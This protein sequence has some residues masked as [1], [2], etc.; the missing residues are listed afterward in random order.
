MAIFEKVSRYAD[1]DIV[2]PVRK[3]GQS[4]GY[5]LVAAED[6]IIPSIFNLAAEA[7]EMW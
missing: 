6:Y 4:A 7:S 3:T 2:M 1:K 5:D